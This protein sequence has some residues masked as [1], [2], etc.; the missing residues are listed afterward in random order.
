ML[1]TGTWQYPSKITYEF[2]LGHIDPK[3]KKAKDE[4]HVHKAMRWARETDKAT[5]GSIGTSKCLFSTKLQRLPKMFK[6]RTSS[7]WGGSTH[8]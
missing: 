8:M 5:P 4:S 2:I 1:W 6:H 3:D 7:V